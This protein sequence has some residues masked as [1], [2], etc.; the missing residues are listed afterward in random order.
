MTH[1][2][3][4]Q[5]YKQ[6]A[7]RTISAGTVCFGFFTVFC[8]LLIMKNSQL[9]ID[10]MTRGLRLCATTVVPSLFPFM[11]LSELIASGGFGVRLL[12]PLFPPLRKLLGLSDGGCC[13]L[14]LGILCGFPI[15]ARCAI[16]AYRD[17]RI[18]REECERVLCIANNPSSAFLIHAVGVS[19]WGN[20]RFG[21]ALY[22]VVLFSSILTG[23]GMRWLG[24]RAETTVTEHPVQE[25]PQ[26]QPCARL[27]TAS[28][29]SAAEGMLLVCAYVVFF[30]ALLGTLGQIFSAWG[31]PS[32]ASAALFCVFEL[33]GG[34]SA[35]SS[36][37][38]PFLAALLCAFAAGWSGLSVHCQILSVCE[39][40]GLSLRPY[41]LSK[42]LQ[43][44]LCILLFGFVL[45]CFPSV[46]SST[47]RYGI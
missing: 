31:I 4:R 40:T 20:H 9:A 37:S 41:L 29:R 1:L 30:S 24:H 34:V 44:F 33:S 28:V 43:G 7:K 8:L 25:S 16:A 19:L 35:A 47:Y 18:G 22:A 21:V 26:P 42:L 14:L 27:F 38:S 11:V 5:G 46:I 13:A 23:I 10:S 32:E 15:G 12:R 6:T 45:T 3:I 2:R 39:G 36:L 17:G